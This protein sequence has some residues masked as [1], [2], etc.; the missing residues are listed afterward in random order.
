[1]WAPIRYN[2]LL[3]S[4]YAAAPSDAP[5]AVNEWRVMM[6]QD[7][8]IANEGTGM[9][10][11]QAYMA[12]A[13]TTLTE[14]QRNHV[15]FLSDCVASVCADFGI[16]LYEPRKKTD[17][18]NNADIPDHEV[19][20][21]DR[22][23]VALSDM[24]IMLCDYPSNGAGQELEIAGQVGIPVI[25][26]AV[27][28]KRI[29]RMVTGSFAINHV[30]TYDDPDDLKKQLAGMLDEL[31]PA[32]RDARHRQLG[33]TIAQ[34]LKDLR[35]RRNISPE[36]LA[37]QVGYSPNMV[38]AIEEMPERVS[39]APIILLRRLAVALNST[40]GELVGDSPYGYG[41]RLTTESV[42]NLEAYAAKVQMPFLHYR[43]LRDEYMNGVREHPLGLL[44]HRRRQV[45]SEVDWDHR[46]RDLMQKLNSGQTE[47]S[48]F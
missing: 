1:M 21:L 40:V 15:F 28:G 24:M 20:L 2:K 13:L 45:L 3:Q 38:S 12:C 14:E 23:K 43:Q 6:M 35:T 34:R 8:Q 11:L 48:L 7:A 16:D 25:F 44:A 46:Y 10:R 26:L 31:V 37:K 47:L 42:D 18:V 4:G 17:P 32:I 36:D 41:D 39:N 29:S 9:D 5:T 33:G 30:I 27:R 19:Y 22:Q